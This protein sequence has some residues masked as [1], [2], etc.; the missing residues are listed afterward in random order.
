VRA[1]IDIQI[2]RYGVAHWHSANLDGNAL[3]GELKKEREGA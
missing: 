3:A 2:H 1:H